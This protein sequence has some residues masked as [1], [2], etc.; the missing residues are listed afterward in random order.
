P[1]DGAVHCTVGDHPY[2]EMLGHLLVDPD[3]GL[4]ELDRP[5]GRTGWD[6]S[7]AWI[8]D[9]SSTENTTAPS[10]QGRF[11]VAVLM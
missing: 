1:V 5:V 4:L 10:G 7:R 3:Q 6:R 2:R 8:W 11:K 9:F